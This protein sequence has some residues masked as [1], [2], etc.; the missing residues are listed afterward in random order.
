MNA[1]NIADLII[2]VR[3]PPAYSF[4]SVRYY[5][6]FEESTNG[7]SLEELAA[8]LAIYAKGVNDNYPPLEIKSGT[9]EEV[10]KPIR[11]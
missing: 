9:P 4:L 5:Y 6:F 10:G 7:R 3:V 8:W 2:V 11:Q 1:M